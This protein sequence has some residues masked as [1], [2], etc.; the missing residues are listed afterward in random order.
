[1]TFIECMFFSDKISNLIVYEM[2]SGRFYWHEVVIAFIEGEL[3]HD[4]RRNLAF[5]EMLTVDFISTES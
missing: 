4:K 2:L 5:Y 3:F 1:M